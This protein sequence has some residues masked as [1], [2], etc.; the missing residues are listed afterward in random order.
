RIDHSAAL[1]APG[2]I[3]VITVDDLPDRGRPIPTRMFHDEAS[4]QFLQRPLADGVVRYSGE[5]VAVIVA[6]TRY[7]AEDAAELL[8]IDYEPIDVVLDSDDA[9]A[10]GAPLLQPQAGTN[11]AGRLVVEY[12][13]VERAFAEADAVVSGEFRIQRHAAV[14]LETRGLL[15]E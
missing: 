12:G 6:D 1:T 15:A 14:P 2:V 7:A 5:P 11:V 8:D 4:R 13:E 3:D 9:V 10:A